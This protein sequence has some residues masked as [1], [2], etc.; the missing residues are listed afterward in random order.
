[1]LVLYI[2][3]S[4]IHKL[5]T[6]DKNDEHL[7]MQLISWK[8]NINEELLEHEFVHRAPSSA[9]DLVEAPEHTGIAHIPG[10]WDYGCIAPLSLVQLYLEVQVFITGIF[11]FAVTYNNSHGTRASI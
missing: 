11:S 1:M 4:V 6:W 2:S 8:L 10:V 9:E 5:L 3:Q 7:H